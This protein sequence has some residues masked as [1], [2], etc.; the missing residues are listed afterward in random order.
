MAEKIIKSEREWRQTL[1]DEQYRVT[2]EKGTERAFTGELCNN[3]A[4][5]VYRCV[6]CGNELFSSQSKYDS[7]SGWPSFWQ[8]LVPGNV[9]EERDS[10]HGMERIEA[11]CSHCNA[12]LGHIFPDG[13][14]PTGLRYCMNS[15]ALEFEACPND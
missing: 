1:S 4:E 15:A 9:A 12:H 2:R 11:L 5:G 7:G 10:S 14:Q 3:K 8:P 13:P 6:C